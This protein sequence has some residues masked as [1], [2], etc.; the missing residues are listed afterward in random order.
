MKVIPFPGGGSAGP[1][2]AWLAELEAALNGDGEGAIA[3]SWRELRQDVRALVPPIAPEFER[4]LG[5]RIAERGAR[6]ASKQP[7]RRLGWL[8]PPGR[9]GA[10]ASV[11]AIGAVVAAV[12]IAGPWRAGTAG[13]IEAPSNQPAVSSNAGRAES[14]T[15]GRAESAHPLPQASNEAFRA[16]KSATAEGS[17]SA[18]AGAASNAPALAP[19]AGGAGLAPGRVQ[20]LAASITLAATPGD[21]QETADRVSRL[22]VS[23]GGFVQSSHVQVQQSGTSEAS[24]DLS[25]PSA[26]LSAALASLGQLAPVRAESQSLQDITNTYD[27][28]RQRL[29]DA[30]AERQALLHALSRATTEGQIDSLHERI[31]QNRGAIAQAQAA[32]QTVSRH[33]ST[34]QVEV[35]VLGDAH[36]GSEGL[37]LHRGLHDAGRVLVV[38]LVVLLIAAAL[39]LPLALLAVALATARRTWRRYQR[40]RV[41]DT[42]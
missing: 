12:V 33:A 14:S 38:T 19:A 18:S 22:A 15:A 20:Q 34:A 40:E 13:P 6:A 17:A 41:L 10:A 21:V 16:A 24:L 39:L 31:S 4:E 35:T 25:L 1:D 3:D 42:R 7:D 32:L 37:T 29:G 28:A 27:A 26:K 2:E 11:A 23:D 5:E 8:R 36:T 9:L 30:T